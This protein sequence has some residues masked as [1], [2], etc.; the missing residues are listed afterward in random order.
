M[1]DELPVH[2]SREELHALEVPASFEATGSFDIRLINHGEALHLHLH[3]DDPLSEVAA[4][5]AGN[6]YVEGDSERLVRVT[7]DR[8]RV[9]EEGLLGKLKVVSAYGAQTRWIDIE[10]AEPAPEE[11]SVQVDESLAQPQHT[12]QESDP[13]VENPTA[14]VLGLGLVAVLIA[15]VAAVSIADLLVVGGALVVVGGVLVALFFLLQEG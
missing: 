8:D 6:H 9:T 3:L 14:L 11:Q 10:L 7:V 2:I 13:V 12:T 4:I 1:T 5:D 15:A